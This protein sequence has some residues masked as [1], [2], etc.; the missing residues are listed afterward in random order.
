MFKARIYKDEPPYP[1]NPARRRY[2]P[3]QN[4]RNNLCTLNRDKA[5]DN[6]ARGRVQ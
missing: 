2:I 4:A 1:G 3:S 6:P 5:A